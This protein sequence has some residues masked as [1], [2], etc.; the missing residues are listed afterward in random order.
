MFFGTRQPLRY[1]ETMIR[2]T[3]LIGVPHRDRTW[4]Y[5]CISRSYWVGSFHTGAPISGWLSQ[6]FVWTLG[7]PKMTTCFSEEKQKTQGTSTGNPWLSNPFKYHV[8][9]HISYIMYHIMYHV[10]Y[11]ISY[12]MY[13]IM[14]HI[15][16]RDNGTILY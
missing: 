9:Y 5:P 8:S 11:H 3:P 12:I 2:R 7:H 16:L 6:H 1:C 13:H 4:Y 15:I 14:Y 10:S